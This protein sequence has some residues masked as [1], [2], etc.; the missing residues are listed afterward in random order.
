MKRREFITLVGGASVVWPL[1]A[2]AQQGDRVRRIGVLMGTDESDPEQKALVS[3]FV[4]ALAD[5][6]WRDGRNIRIDYRW[7]SG[8]TG[9]LREQAAELAG[10]TPDVVVAQGTPATTALRHSTPA[11]AIVFVMVT[12]PVGSGLV[13]SLAHPAGNITGFT[14]YEYTLGGKWLEILRE[15]APRVN[16]V[17]V[18]HNADNAAAPGQLRTIEAAAP[19]LGVQVTAAPVRSA[20]EIEQ[21][22]AIFGPGV[23][24]GLVVL[25]DFITLTHRDLIVTLAAH[26]H[27]PAIFNLR[28]FVK[29]G[30]LVSYSINP[31]DLFHRAASYVDR[32]LKGA[33]AA[34][35]PV[36]QPTKF[37]LHVNLKTA[38]ALGLEVPQT[39]LATADE[40]I[41]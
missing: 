2:R 35:L 19:A 4:H 22:I 13:S 5:L 26:H 39:L 8:D 15:I 23:N 36:Q 18:V 33:K 16:R 11:T 31:T 32:I 12:D 38:K 3:A 27:L 21:A 10:L 7:A 24:G 9:R 6:G 41:E 40:V 30:G 29:S 17:A 25:V 28:V 37:E 20:A 34:D 1:A 14:N